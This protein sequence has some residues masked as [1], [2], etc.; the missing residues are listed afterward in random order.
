[1]IQFSELIHLPHLRYL[2]RQSFPDDSRRFVRFYFEHVFRC[3][4]TLVFLVDNH[5]ASALQMIPYQ[6]QLGDSLSTGAYLS[7]VMT[8]TSYRRRGY[9]TQ[10]LEA[11]FEHLR[12]R[13]IPYVFLIPQSDTLAQWYTRFGFVACEANPVPPRNRVIKSPEQWRVLRL[14][15]LEETGVWLEKEIVLQGEQ[16]GM[17]KRLLPDVADIRSLSMGMMLDD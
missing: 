1:M 8:H 15:H 14:N 9:M 7:G 4:Q 16:K 17:I 2:W 3:D 12:S 10:L 13:K 6:L 5:V 11:A